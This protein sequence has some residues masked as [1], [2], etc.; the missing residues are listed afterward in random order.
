M[1]KAGMKSP[2][3]FFRSHRSLVLIRSQ[4][5]FPKLNSSQQKVRFR[6]GSENPDPTVDIDV[7]TRRPLPR[8]VKVGRVNW[9]GKLKAKCQMR[10]G[11]SVAARTEG[12]YCG[13]F[14][15]GRSVCRGG[16]LEPGLKVAITFAQPESPE[17]SAFERL[18]NQRSC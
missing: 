12:A 17:G 16:N 4:S 18:G 13:T 5:N 11:E 14:R 7:F 8:V 9:R 6:S 3:P 15:Y 10:F 2:V 1:T